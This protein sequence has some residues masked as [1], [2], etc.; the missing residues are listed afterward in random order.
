M[1]WSGTGTFSRIVTTVSPAT[2]G[3]TIDVADQNT[4][5]ADVTN[6]INA[7]LAKNGENTPTSDL[8]MGGQKH[9]GVADGVAANDYAALGQLQDGFGTYAEDTGAANAYE[10]ALSPALTAYI[11]GQVFRFKALATNTG[12]STIDINGLGAKSITSELGAAL[13]AGNIAAGGIYSIVYDGTQFQLNATEAT[14]E[15][16]ALTA[17]DKATAVLLTPIAGTT[18]FVLSD[19]GGLFKA[20]T[21]APIAT[22]ADDG[23]TYCGTQFIPTG[24]NGSA[25]WVR[26]YDGVENINWYSGTDLAAKW[27]TYRA[28]LTQGNRY[29]L[30]IPVPDPD[31][32]AA[33]EI[34]TGVWRWKLASPMQF[35]DPENVGNIYWQ[36]EVVATVGISQMLLFGPTNKTE[37]IYFPLGIP[38]LDCDGLAD[39]GIK[40]Q[41]ASRITFSN[42]VKIVD[43][44]TAVFI[45]DTVATASQISFDELYA[46]RWQ[47]EAVL[48]SGTSSNAVADIKIGRLWGED[49]QQVTSNGVLIKGVVSRLNILDITLSNQPTATLANGVLMQANAAGRPNLSLYFG[50]VDALATTAFKTEDQSSGV[51]GKI[52]GLNIGHIM[53][54]TGTVA[55]NL[56]WCNDPQ[57][58]DWHPDTKTV[59]IGANTLR[60]VYNDY[61]SYTG[62]M[63]GL[64]TS[65]TATMN[66]TRIGRQVVIDIATITGTSNATTMTITGAPVGIRPTTTT[67]YAAARI[68][69][70]G[71]SSFGVVRMTTAGTLDF[72]SDSGGG[73]FTDSGTKGCSDFIMTYNLD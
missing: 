69:D 29:S 18:L 34:A 10:I 57:I 35:D 68:Q 20:V 14:E 27:N 5:T 16:N 50:K 71:L 62:T 43:C 39:V 12:A 41:G 48:L 19:G 60:A 37:D 26:D 22:Y 64:T 55:A 67:K 32:P 17:V 4:Y 52:Q 56:E 44:D 6:G 21:G 31:D 70:A 25:G 40:I 58:Q 45:D 65:P 13:D 47:N 49:A 72:R 51:A 23:G 33:T 38:Y 2:N 42:M 3:T 9:T 28:N 11:A 36:G 61:G 66:Y 15:N 73:A 54:R 53:V 30:I 1:A 24:G 8:P 46:A 59:T 7:C 63:T